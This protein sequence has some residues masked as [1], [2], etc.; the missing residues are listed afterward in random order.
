ML[1][2]AHLV[3]Y[4]LHIVSQGLCF[5]LVLSLPVNAEINYYRLFRVVY[6]VIR[7]L[8]F[9]CKYHGVGFQTRCTLEIQLIVMRA[10]LKIAS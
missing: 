5:K 10:L 8:N 6:R 3:L 4:D 1:S 9:A 2:Y 7:K